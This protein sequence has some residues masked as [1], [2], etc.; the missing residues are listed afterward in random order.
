MKS[1]FSRVLLLTAVALLSTNLLAQ[2][3]EKYWVTFTDKAGVQFNPLEYFHPKAIERRVKNGIAICDSSDFPVSEKYVDQLEE[4][5]VEIKMTSRWLNAACCFSGDEGIAKVQGLPFVKSVRRMP[6]SEIETVFCSYE[7]LDE[8]A[9]ETDSDFFLPQT[10]SLG[11]EVF[12]EKGFSGKGIRVAVFD[13]GFRKAEKRENLRHLFENNQIERT[14][15]F[16]GND[17]SV[18]HHSKHGTNVLTCLAGKTDS[19]LFGLATDATF[20][21]ARTEYN[22]REPLSEEENWLAAAEWADKHGADIISS[23]LGYTGKWYFQDEMDGKTSLVARAANAAFEKGILVVNS[24]GNEAGGDWQY[25]VTPADAEGVLAVGGVLGE[26]GVHIDFSSFGPTGDVR[27]KPNVCAFGV[28]IT[29][30]KEER[31]KQKKVYGTSFSAPLISGYAACVLQAFPDWDVKKLFSEIEKSGRLYPY[32]DYA[33]GF[34]MPH[35]SYFFIENAQQDP[36]DHNWLEIN[37]GEVIIDVGAITPKLTEDLLSDKLFFHQADKDGELI[38]FAVY[39]LNRSQSVTFSTRAYTCVVRAWWA[40]NFIEKEL[41][42][43]Q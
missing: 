25:L 34:G 9:L 19:A 11:A 4:A 29:E 26:N 36:S 31:D 38:D 32:F 16:C 43:G 41:P 23:S 2:E 18:Y 37:E 33:H 8:V 24:M 10:K 21:L 15:D 30:I 42:C 5:G 35:A 28:A 27:I 39:S 6:S 20:L 13:A 14:I 22:L 40:G 17:S 12:S 7:S 1:C 3:E